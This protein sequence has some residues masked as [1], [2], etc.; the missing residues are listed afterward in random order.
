M[1][2]VALWN[3]HTLLDNKRTAIRPSATVSRELSRYNTDIAAISETRVLGQN[4]IEVVAG[5]YTFFLQG[6]PVGER[7]DH[8]VSFAIRT[9]LVNH[10]QGNYPIGINER[11][12]T[13]CLP[14]HWLVA[15]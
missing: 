5:G 9:K 7:S 14:L 8:G 6:K 11:L 3:V 13:M 15:C 10:L 2:N 4:V 1:L 12:M